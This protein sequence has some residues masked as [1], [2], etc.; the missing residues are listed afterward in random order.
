MF[1]GGI[2]AAAYNWGWARKGLVRFGGWADAGF[3]VAAFFLG[4]GTATQRHQ[5]PLQPDGKPAV[6]RG[7]KASDHARCALALV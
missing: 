6:R 4:G 7:R 5:N 1:V 3:T 2:Y